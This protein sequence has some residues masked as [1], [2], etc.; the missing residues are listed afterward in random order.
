M[1]WTA[2]HSEMRASVSRILLVCSVA[3]AGLALSCTDRYGSS[4]GGIGQQA[5]APQPAPK[6]NPKPPD[7][8]RWLSPRQARQEV[9]QNADAFLLCVADKEQYDQG[10]V[11]G[12]VLIPVRALAVKVHRNDLFPE[13]NRGR[14]PRKDQPIIVY[15]W[16]KACECP[17]IPTYSDLAKRVLAEEG[18]G[19]V[20]VVDG[21][22]RA[23]IKAGL[24]VEKGKTA[25]SPS[26]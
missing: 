12:S 26:E 4:S 7:T 6:P 20:A 24:P 1:G 21:G 2:G 5:T 18:F 10:H 25:S 14:V 11:A 8:A 16:W 13:I 23:W 3:G 9:G 17:A 22:M 15:C 19:K